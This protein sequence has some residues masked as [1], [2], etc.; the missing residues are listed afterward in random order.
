MTTEK[1]LTLLLNL[2]TTVLVVYGILQ[3]GQMF[4]PVVALLGMVLVITYLLLGPVRWME[5][6]IAKLSARAAHW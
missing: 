6:G 4:Y 5:T 2:V 1:P 3:L